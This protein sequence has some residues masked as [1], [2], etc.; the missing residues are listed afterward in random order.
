MREESLG[1]HRGEG[2]GSSGQSTLELIVALAL[3][4]MS[5]AAAVAVFFGGRVLLLDAQ[6]ARE[7]QHL[8]RA[9][10]EN[11]RLRAESAFSGLAS[12]SSTYK[13]FL[14]ETIVETVDADT[15]KVTT[16]VSWQADPLRSNSVET[17]T[18]L[19]NWRNAAP[20]PDPGDSG[21]G[22]IS[23]DWRNP[24]TL[25]SVDLGPGNSAT[26]L[27]VVNKIVYMS[28]EASAAAKPDF[29]IID[30]TDGQ[31]PFIISSLNTGPS[32]NAVDASVDYAYVAN[33][34]AGA[35]LQ[36]IGI[37]NPLSPVVAG[38]Y[39]AQG[40]S[41]TSHGKTV[42][43]SEGKAYLGLNKV[44]GPEFH[45]VDVSNPS[46]PTSLGT[47]EVNDNVNDIYV[48]GGRAYLATDLGGAGLIV[49]DV[50]HP[51]AIALLGQSYSVDTNSVYLENPAV[52]LLGPAQ[53]LY[54]VDA[55]NPPAIATLGTLSAGDTV[56]DIAK[57]DNLAFI[58]SSNSNKEFQVITIATPTD[59]TPWSS[60]NFPQ[61]ATGI[62]YEDNIVYVSVRSNDA[63]RIITSSP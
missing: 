5:I 3:I 23:G 49:L 9:L 61:V 42:F 29:F 57:R 43:Y 60:F 20:P 26:D 37:S 53:E 46:N 10:R 12:A 55:S 33:D 8:D 19:T 51:A 59:P 25:G 35:E 38:T 32:L 54:V 62:D 31:N 21:G 58:A 13:E 6:F 15:K 50:S 27:D 41:G 14:Q 16:R 48:R 40:V 24:R 1:K 36:I 52:L 44:S 28:A 11:A 47:Y 45:V 4:V 22:G 34:A 7:A 18:W 17:I 2:R 63:L 30:A 39:A 56:N